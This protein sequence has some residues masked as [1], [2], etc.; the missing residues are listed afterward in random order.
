MAAART[1]RQQIRISMFILARQK[2]RG[3]SHFFIFFGQNAKKFRPCFHEDATS[4]HN[5]NTYKE[6]KI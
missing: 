1:A 4:T 5:S 2:I 6:E 3:N